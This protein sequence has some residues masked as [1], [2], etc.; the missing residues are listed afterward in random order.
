M[1]EAFLRCMKMKG[2]RKATKTL[3][4]GYY[5]H[6]CKP[7]GGKWIWGERKKKQGTT[8]LTR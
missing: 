8:H 1:P 3:P 4:D 2:S 6:G 5:I 7:P